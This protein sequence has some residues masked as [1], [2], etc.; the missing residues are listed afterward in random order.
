MVFLP[1]D[2]TAHPTKP[3]EE[4]PT[5]DMAQL[6]KILE[7]Q[8][9]ARS[10]R[11]A[12]AGLFDGSAFRYGSLLVITLF[13]FASLGVLYAILSQIQRPPQTIGAPPVAAQHQPA[14][15]KS[16]TAVALPPGHP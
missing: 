12:P 2:E 14:V 10:A 4:T 6:L 15:A 16:G 9:A 1:M 5:P 8:S 13:A 3:P 11:R 7:A